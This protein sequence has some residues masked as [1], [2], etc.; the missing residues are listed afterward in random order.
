[1]NLVE[2]VR[3]M[4]AWIQ[5][6]VQSRQRVQYR[7]TVNTMVADHQYRPIDV[8]NIICSKKRKLKNLKLVQP[9]GTC[10]VTV[11]FNHKCYSLCQVNN[12]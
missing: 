4:D 9:F 7:Y 10:A 3:S 8:E 12:T 1:M 6:D 5:E 2:D 11:S